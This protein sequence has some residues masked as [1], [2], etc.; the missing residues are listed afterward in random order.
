MED[1]SQVTRTSVGERQSI[2]DDISSIVKSVTQQVER[3]KCSFC[4][5][6]YDPIQLIVI[7]HTVEERELKCCDGCFQ[8]CY[9]KEERELASD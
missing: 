4:G 7:E 6:L 5:T 9:E 3:L 8:T 2:S 1:V